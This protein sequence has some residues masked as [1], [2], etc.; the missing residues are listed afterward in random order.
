MQITDKMIDAGAKAHNPSAWDTDEHGNYIWLPRKRREARAEA[1]KIIVA[2]LKSAQDKPRRP[3]ICEGCGQN[4]SVHHRNCVLVVRRTE[5]IR[6]KPLD[7]EVNMV[8]DDRISIRENNSYQYEVFD[9][10]K[11]LGSFQ[12]FKDA[13]EFAA[14][15]TIAKEA[16]PFPVT[17]GIA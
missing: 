17:V 6:L 4:R 14:K 11:W 2:A 12:Y 3:P 8:P 9:G 5:N 1:R 10:K 15:Q 7:N 16:R 13:S